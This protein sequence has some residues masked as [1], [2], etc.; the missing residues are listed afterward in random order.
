MPPFIKPIHYLLGGLALVAVVS[1]YGWFQ[2]TVNRKV[3]EKVAAIAV[4]QVAVLQKTHDSTVAVLVKERD[5]LVQVQKQ[6]VAVI[7]KTQAKAAVQLHAAD[8]A[9]AALRADLDSTHQV[10]LDSVV[11]G[12]RKRIAS[13]SITIAATQHL[14]EL[15]KAETETYRQ[16]NQSLRALNTSLAAQVEAVQPEGFHLKNELLAAAIGAAAWIVID[17]AVN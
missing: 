8:S 6:T 3:A 9:A 10:A 14:V 2:E 1:G 15:A 5:S 11:A 17:K 4:E 13:D 7:A 12:Y 16:E